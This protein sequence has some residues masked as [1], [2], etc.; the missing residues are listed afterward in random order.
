VHLEHETGRLAEDLRL[1]SL[2][3]V[4]EPLSF[5]ELEEV[6]RGRPRVRLG[7]GKLVYVP[8]DFCESLF[9]LERGR[10]RLYKRVPRGRE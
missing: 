4:F 6:F 5:G 10:V 9:V 2:V 3:D 7:A 1:L 8:N